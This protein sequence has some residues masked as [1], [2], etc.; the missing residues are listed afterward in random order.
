VFLGIE[1]LAKLIDAVVLF[2]RIDRVSRGYY[3][4]TLVPLIEKPK[5]ATGHEITEAHVR[6]LEKMIQENPQYWLWSHRRWKY[7]PEDFSK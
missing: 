5:E 2:Y 3:T 7:K 4:Y 1:K 6:Y